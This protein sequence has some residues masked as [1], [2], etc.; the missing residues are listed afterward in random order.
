MKKSTKNERILVSVT[1][2]TPQVVTE[3]LYAL[4][5]GEKVYPTQIHIITTGGGREC[6]LRQLLDEKEG[7][8]HAFCWDYG[9]TGKIRFD[10][11]TVHVVE[12]KKGKAIPDIRSPE[13]NTLVA[14]MTVRLMQKFCSDPDTSVY[15]S[16]AGGRKTMGF[17]AGYALS[18]F[19]RSQDRLLHVL[20]SPAFEN[21]PEFFYPTQTRQTI[22][23]R[24]GRELAARDAE[25]AMADIP[26]VRM[27]RGL[28][29]S[30]VLG[31]TSFSQAV[32]DAQSHV[33]PEVSLRF[34]LAGGKVYCAGA[35]VPMQPIEVAVYLWTACCWLRD[36]KP[37]RPERNEAQRDEFLRVYAMVAGQNSA[38]YIDSKDKLNARG[39]SLLPLYQTNRTRINDKICLAL[40][41]LNAQPY[42]IHS[43]GK[44]GATAY[45]IALRPEQI[46][47]PGRVQ[48]ELS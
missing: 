42:L 38:K 31:E 20:V 45:A 16:I 32:R 1:G 47:L 14:D 11:T 12:E 21:N 2:M 40:G 36:K 15:V 37:M 4:L 8:F 6:I 18:L 48:H 41:S 34:D 33:L 23:T 7:Q 10:E 3:T 25:I 39:W 22:R 43:Y 35:E 29:E 30:L 46:S 19:G 26:F 24:D 9:L 44:R 27:G 28:S 5:E 17:F 13:E